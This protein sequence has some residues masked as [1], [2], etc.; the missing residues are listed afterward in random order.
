MSYTGYSVAQVQN[1]IAQQAA[2]TAQ[3]GNLSPQQTTEFTNIAEATAQTES[4]FNPYAENI[5]P[6]TEASYGVY[7][8]N[9]LGGEGTPYV[10]NPSA[11]FNPQLNS[12]I[13]L[14]SLLQAFQSNPTG[15]PGQIAAAAQRPA[16]P[17][18]YAQTVD[19]YYQSY[20]SGTN[21]L[22][23]AQLGQSF[24][25]PQQPPITGS[26]TGAPAAPPV[27]FKWYEPWTW[28]QTG[29]QFLMRGVV[30][31]FGVGLIYMGTKMVLGASGSGAAKQTIN[32]VKSAAIE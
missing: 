32:I 22:S 31:I 4:G 10:Q 14:S 19:S 1:I 7:Q 28:G 24:N 3:Q 2:A 8:L 25:G 11:L 20:A 23:A 29:G 16:N 15:D 21:P 30:G 12:Q 26:A 13:A 5:N 9:T 17:Q 18:N 6:P 27:N